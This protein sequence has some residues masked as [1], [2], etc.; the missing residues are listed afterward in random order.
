MNLYNPTILHTQA[1]R[2]YGTIYHD[3]SDHITVG[4]YVTT[5]FAN[6][7]N[8]AATPI[9][10]YIGYPIRQAPANVT[11]ADLAA[12]LNAFLAYAKYDGG[13]CQTAAICA[14]T[15][16]YNAYLSRQYTTLEY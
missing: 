1:P 5:A 3:H 11:G 2:D 10:Y 7:S 6:Y 16:T 9:S 15:A 12:K 8:E 4:K 14:R 13:V